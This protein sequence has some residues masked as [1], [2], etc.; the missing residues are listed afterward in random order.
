MSKHA[1][2]KHANNGH[3]KRRPVEKSK[4]YVSKP[5]EARRRLYRSIAILG[6]VVILLSVAV[7]W[8]YFENLRQARVEYVKLGNTVHIESTPTAKPVLTAEPE[9]TAE[10]SEEPE[11]TPEPTPEPAHIPVDFAYLQSRNSDVDGWIVVEGTDIDYPVLY[12]TSD[13]YYYLDHT[14]TGTYSAAGSIFV[15]DYN[16]RDFVDF[17]TVIYGHNMRDGSMFAQLHYFE[18][19]DFFDSYETITI[20]TE[21]SVLTYQIFAAYVRDNE[22]LMQYYSYGTEEDRQD[23]ID[24]IYDHD[25]FFNYDIEV[26][27]DDRIVT[28]STCTGWTYTRFLVQGVLISEEPGVCVTE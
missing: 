5:K 23:Y 4:G 16:S 11:P 2:G 25:G 24:D 12:D 28:L 19:E 20:Y 7:L 9:P 17:N 13:D 22:H 26:T 21:D 1:S 3:A 10:A 18:D 14:R 27:P 6:C 15:E 8:L